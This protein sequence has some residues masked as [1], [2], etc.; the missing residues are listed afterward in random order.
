VPR[1]KDTV[2]V[3]PLVEGDGCLR[4]L[5]SCWGGEA[6]DSVH[7]LLGDVVLP[8][9]LVRLGAPEDDEV[10]LGLW[11]LGVHLAL[12]ARSSAFRAGFWSLPY[13]PRVL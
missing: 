4:P 13:W 10:A 3:V 2:R 9:G 1:T 12:F 6:V 8:V 11:E 5:E 7:L